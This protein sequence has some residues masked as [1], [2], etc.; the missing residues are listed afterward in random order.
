V[1]EKSHSPP[2]DPE[3]LARE[4]EARLE[5]VRRGARGQRFD[6]AVGLSGGRDSTY[7][8]YRLVRK[9]NLRCLA[10]YYRTPFT[11]DVTD[12]NVRRTVESLGVTLQEIDIS[13]SAHKRLAREML[14]LWLE[15]PTDKIVANMMCAPCKLVNRE[16]YRIAKAHGIK[17]LIC[18]AN[19]FEAVQI[20]AS[21]SQD[22]AIPTAGQ[23]TLRRQFQRTLSMVKMGIGALAR[24]RRL[25]RHVPLGVQASLMYVH[26][27]TPYLR[28]R[29]PG[30]QAIEYFYYSPW[31]QE[32][33]EKALAELGWELPPGC[34]STWKSDCSFAE[35]KN[36]AFKRMTGLTYLD[37]FMS[38][39]VRAGAVDREEALRRLKVEGVVS[40][41]RLQDVCATLD[42][43]PETPGL[44]RG[45]PAARG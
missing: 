26:T 41:K 29:Y 27:H 34:N 25:L 28:L 22:A 39:M 24:S 2:A 31:R 15:R 13:A 32:E 6:C 11:S 45:V 4:L 16:L 40:E 23:L 38:N 43:P 5:E 33:C 19:P 35:F 30:I 8:L 1:A 36:L 3:V 37:A 44:A 10:A 12:A 18:G 14:L 20:A 17:A 7:L 21:I 42:L 9:H